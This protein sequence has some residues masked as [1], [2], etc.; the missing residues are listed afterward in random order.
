[1]SGVFLTAAINGAEIT[2]DDTPALPLTPEEVAEEA[3]RCV[4][5]GAAILHLHGRRPDGTP[6]QDIDTFRDYFSAIRERTDAIV[7][8]STGGAVGMALE[9]RIEALAL[10]PDM[11]TLTTGTVNFGEDV[12][13]NTRP[14][15]REIARRLQQFGVVPEVEVFEMGMLDEAMRLHEEGLLPKRPHVDFVFGVPG[16]M[17]ARIEH[18]DHLVSCLPDGWTWSV[19]AVG[20]HQRCFAQAAFE[21]GGHVRVGLEDNLYLE[22]GRL[23]AGSWELVRAAAEDAKA[24]GRTVLSIAE[25]RR[26]LG[27]IEIRDPCG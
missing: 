14:M 27:V 26:L 4:D 25:A 10:R 20:R 7:Q 9:E 11:A 12:F 15:I 8:F 22:K 19:A 13:V 6:T 17:A 23:A 21:R 3:A 18:L 16:A 24:A 1:M 2:R 5:E